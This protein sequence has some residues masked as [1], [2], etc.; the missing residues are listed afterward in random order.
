MMYKFL[1]TML[2]KAYV[3]ILRDLLVKAIDD[4]DEE[5]DDMVLNILDRIFNYK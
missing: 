5:W 1:Y 3:E 2:C 4:P